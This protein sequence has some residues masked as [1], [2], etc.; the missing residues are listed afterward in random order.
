MSS[1]FLRQINK[2]IAYKDAPIYA[3]SFSMTKTCIL[4]KI[5]YRAP[6]IF[7]FNK[8]TSHSKCTLSRHG[9]ILKIIYFC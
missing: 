4:T 7:D 5:L 9:N 3:F 6:N 1:I 8:D 2:D